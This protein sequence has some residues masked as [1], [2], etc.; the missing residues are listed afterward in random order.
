MAD[1]SARGYQ[2]NYSDLDPQLFDVGGR[3]QKA[4]KVLAVLKDYLGPIDEAHVLDVSS[5]TGIMAKCF[6]RGVGRI[7]GIDIDVKALGYAAENQSAPNLAYSV[8]DALH[9]A[10]PDASFDVVI[11]N[12]MYEHVPDAQMLMDE[13]FRVLRPGGICYFGANNRLMLIENHYGKLPFLSIIPKPLAHVYLRVL[14][15]AK[16]YYETHYTVWTLRKLTRRFEI[17]DYT[18]RIVHEPERFSATDMIQPG[19][20]TQRLSM[21]LLRHAYWLFP[22]Y[23]WLLRKPA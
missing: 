5:S 11:C 4:E 20:A 7:T 22:G 10:F 6:A 13:I 18:Q 16:Y 3:T 14:G 23:V 15:R 21:L 8:M 1:T 19:S 9:L 12:Q 17:E 2:H